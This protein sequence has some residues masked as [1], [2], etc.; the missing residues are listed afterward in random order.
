[1]SNPGL[2]NTT[3][4]QYEYDCFVQNLTNVFTSTHIRCVGAVYNIN[5]KILV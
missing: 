5:V 3:I 2:T 1:M 4:S